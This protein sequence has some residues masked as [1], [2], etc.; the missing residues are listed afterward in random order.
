MPNK[1]TA[2]TG[3]VRKSELKLVAAG[4][5]IIAVLFSAVMFRGSQVVVPEGEK[6]SHVTAKINGDE[7]RLE[8]ADNPELRIKGLGGRQGLNPGE[9]MLFVFERPGTE[10]FWMKDVNFSIDIIWFD[11]DKRAIHILPELSPE[12]YP[13]S[14]CPPSPA[15]YVV[16][17]PAGTTSS[18]SLKTGD[19]LD[20]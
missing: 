3:S 11:A 14:F 8:L 1:E 20:L 10:C 2:K 15:L 5:V 9:G 12:T 13:K 17:L 4:V 19:L 6:R 18:I 7:F 16:E